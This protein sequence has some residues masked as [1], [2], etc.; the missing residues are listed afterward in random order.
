MT[1]IEIRLL[2]YYNDETNMSA[3]NFN[4]TQISPTRGSTVN[5][6]STIYFDR[7]PPNL[8]WESTIHIPPTSTLASRTFF[9][10]IRSI[11]DVSN[12]EVDTRITPSGISQIN[13]TCRL[14]PNDLTTELIRIQSVATI[15]TLINST[16]NEITFR[17]NKSSMAAF[18]RCFVAK[19]LCGK[20]NV[21]FFI[22]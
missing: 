14:D 22:R 12:N 16:P 1:T 8:F 18:R 15:Y 3:A 2:G 13:G 11:E 9:N 5:M 17:N 20:D 10:T 6:S 4:V 21:F 7:N 19:R